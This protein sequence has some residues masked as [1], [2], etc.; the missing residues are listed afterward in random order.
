MLL[1]MSVVYALRSYHRFGGIVSSL[2]ELS[3][4]PVMSGASFTAVTLTANI[5]ESCSPPGSVTVTLMVEI[6]EA[7]A[8]GL[9]QFM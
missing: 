9:E 2:V 7:L 8:A 6:P 4:I 3:G 5:S 1:S